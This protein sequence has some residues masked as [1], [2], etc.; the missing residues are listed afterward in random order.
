M[1]LRTVTAVPEYG[2]EAGITLDG[3]R[4]NG[5]ASPYPL[6]AQTEDGRLVQFRESEVEEIARYRR[7]HRNSWGEWVPDGDT[8]SMTESEAATLNS[9]MRQMQVAAYYERED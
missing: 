2:L 9:T 6:E 5:T 7:W 8:H 1:Q 3:R 4:K